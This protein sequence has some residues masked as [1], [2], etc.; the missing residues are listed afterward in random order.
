MPNFRAAF[1]HCRGLPHTAILRHICFKLALITGKADAWQ[2]S[3]YLHMGQ[4]I[5]TSQDYRRRAVGKKLLSFEGGDDLGSIL[6]AEP[7]PISDVGCFRQQAEAG[8]PADCSVLNISVDQT[9]T[10]LLLSRIDADKTPLV[11]RVACDSTSSIHE[12]VAKISEIIK[13]SDDVISTCNDIRDTADEDERATRTKEWWARRD[14][15]DTKMGD[16]LRDL[17]DHIFGSW[18]TFFLG[19]VDNAAIARQLRDQALWVAREIDSLVEK[20]GELHSTSADPLLCERLLDGM[21]DGVLNEAQLSDGIGEILGT[22]PSTA[23]NSVHA[24]L[25]S[26]TLPSAL[27]K[28]IATVNEQH[29][30]SPPTSRARSNQV[31]CTPF[32]TPGRK[33]RPGAVTG[34]VPRSA[35]KSYTNKKAVRLD[36]VP[37]L[38]FE[39]PS[40]PRGK[41]AKQGWIKRQP[42]CLVLDSSIHGIPFEALA[43]LEHRPVCR[44]PSADIL[45]ERH[46]KQGSSTIVDDTKT[47]YVLNP[48]NDLG[49]TQQRFE[50]PFAKNQGWT[51][52]VG[53][54]PTA[55]DYTA[56]LTK[57]DTV[58]YCGHG[59]GEQFFKGSQLRDV[60][61]TA[62]M[63]LMGCSSGKLRGVGDFEPT[64]IALQ[65]LL[66][67]APAV[68]SNLW[69]VTDVDID[70][71]TAAL[72]EV[73]HGA[74]G[75]KGG[76]GLLE[77]V[78][79]ARTRCRM[80][81][82]NGAAPIVYG[83]NVWRTK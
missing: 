14:V 29:P 17:E 58:V 48:S 34:K 80:K 18:K 59:A 15:L 30:D 61:C 19:K 74:P 62:T 13:G 55:D 12:I 53:K 76:L 83:L 21:I 72:L 26:R 69:D 40:K 73:W 66:A 52:I 39:T 64:G 79:I 49:G 50:E 24:G 78:S 16:T 60:P 46:A 33:A 11:H 8:F 77:A 38:S 43:V 82:L 1:E 41:P 54:P 68:V 51:G 75:E 23:P 36:A 32:K 5:T 4:G 28:V 37:K 81:Y 27:A 6:A 25:L 10:I 22:A 20:H 2:T 65:Y 45:L 7:R 35:K 31:A 47:F 70:S 44:M 3:F 63:L 67:G 57:R 71:V 9:G 42:I 56:A